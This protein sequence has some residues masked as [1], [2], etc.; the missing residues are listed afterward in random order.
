MTVTD[1]ARVGLDNGNRMERD[2]DRVDVAPGVPTDRVRW[3]PI[4]AGTFIAL[5]T[6]AILSTLGAAVGFS[7]YDH[8]ADDLRNFA[9]VGGMWG[10]LSLIIA[11]AVGGFVAARSS[12]V[13]GGD[14]GMLNGLL[15]A[16][17]G[18][19]LMLFLVGSVATS[20]ANTTALAA[21]RDG[22]DGAVTASARAN[23]TL[24]NETRAPENADDAERAR[25]VGSRTAWSTLISMLLT[26]GAAS[27]A[28]Y[29]GAR[30][31]RIIAVRRNRS[32]N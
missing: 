30:D 29:I 25:R 31:D 4:L 10:I 18:I 23:D 3:G 22:L 20:A 2:I 11:F 7:S 9:M 24:N 16:A 5:T 8:G 6:L 13:R 12:A 14:N 26:V 32:P 1:N 21:N 19:P 28:G 15:V 17:F 27:V